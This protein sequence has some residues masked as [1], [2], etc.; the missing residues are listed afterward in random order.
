MGENHLA[1]LVAYLLLHLERGVTKVL[2]MQ[3]GLIQQGLSLTAK[4][5]IL[6]L[7]LGS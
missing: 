7:Q 1:D 6:L 2:L 5:H 4:N 3:L